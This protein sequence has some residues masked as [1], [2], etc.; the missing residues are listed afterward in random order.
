MF[1]TENKARAEFRYKAQYKMA[2]W[3]WIAINFITYATQFLYLPE[4][5]VHRMAL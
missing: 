3:L 5:K 1:E 4:Q 2:T